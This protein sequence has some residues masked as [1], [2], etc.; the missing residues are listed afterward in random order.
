MNVIVAKLKYEKEYKTC[1][2]ISVDPY[3]CL[4]LF[5]CMCR[6]TIAPSAASTLNKDSQKTE[7]RGGGGGRE[8][9]KGLHDERKG[10]YSKRKH[11]FW[12]AF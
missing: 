1:S 6:Y 8:E 5:V 11:I 3:V 4:L 12:T 9:T 10:F 2:P 7:W